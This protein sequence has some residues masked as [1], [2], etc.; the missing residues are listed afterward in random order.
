MVEA[1]I[2]NKE[3]IQVVLTFQQERTPIPPSQ[4]LCPK[5]GQDV[6]I[7]TPA[8]A[9]EREPTAVVLR[10][11]CESAVRT[12]LEL[13]AKAVSWRR[14]VRFQNVPKGTRTPRQAPR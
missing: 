2:V 4:L 14:R 10:G 7:A 13:I 6:E 8:S 11:C 12:R 5:H 9:F 3:L 1:R